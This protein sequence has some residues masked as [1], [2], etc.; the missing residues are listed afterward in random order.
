MSLFY[1]LRETVLR[2]KN[3]ALLISLEILLWGKKYC[4]KKST[5]R[6]QV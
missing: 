6:F 2:G 3:I 5:E 4:F 1:F